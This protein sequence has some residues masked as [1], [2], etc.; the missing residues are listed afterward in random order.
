MRFDNGEI[1]KMEWNIISFVSE[2]LIM[3]GLIVI[4]VFFRFNDFQLFDK[5]LVTKGV[6]F[7]CFDVFN[8]FY[9]KSNYNCSFAY[10][11]YVFKWLLGLHKIFTL[12]IFQNAR[13]KC[14]YMFELRNCRIIVKLA[15][16]GKIKWDI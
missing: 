4:I 13:V 11:I 10:S 7:L 9:N 6:L 16:G 14:C 2:L 5:P 15:L 3:M 12:V 8:G 1:L